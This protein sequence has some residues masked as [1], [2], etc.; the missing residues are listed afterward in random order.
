MKAQATN[1]ALEPAMQDE[2]SYLKESL[3]L[4]TTCVVYADFHSLIS[5]CVKQLGTGYPSCF[6]SARALRSFIY[7]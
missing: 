4:H 3:P 5:F 2:L 7:S 1:K 6:I